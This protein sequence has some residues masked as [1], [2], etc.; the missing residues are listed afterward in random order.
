MELRHTE[1][2]TRA[3]LDWFNVDFDPSS[4]HSIPIS[5][6][7]LEEQPPKSNG[8]EL[9]GK[10]DDQEIENDKLLELLSSIAN[11]YRKLPPLLPMTVLRCRLIDNVQWDRTELPTQDKEN[12]IEVSARPAMTMQQFISLLVNTLLLSHS[13]GGA[14]FEMRLFLSPY[15][16]LTEGTRD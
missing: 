6:R 16:V 12:W 8:E 13:D 14:D 10:R 5:L 2:W 4:Y 3:H 11:A 9:S 15:F 1:S 7:T